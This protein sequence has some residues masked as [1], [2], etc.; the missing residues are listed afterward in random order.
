MTSAV[1]HEPRPG[2]TYPEVLLVAENE[3]P[4]RRIALGLGGPLAGVITFL[5]VTPLVT[6]GL[7]G[8]DAGTVRLGGAAAVGALG[9]T[10]RRSRQCAIASSPAARS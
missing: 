9:R 3:S 7:I 4:A 5:V 6:A 1:L 10:S 8:L 2:V